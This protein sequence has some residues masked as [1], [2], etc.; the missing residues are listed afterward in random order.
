M[1]PIKTCV[2]G[3]GLAGLTFHVPFILALSDLFTLYAVL[4]RNPRSPGGKVKERFGVE[5]KIYN[6]I[7]EVVGDEEIEL[8]IVATPNDTHYALAKAALEAGKHGRNIS[9]S[10]LFP[11]K[12]KG[13][14]PI[15]IPEQAVGLGPHCPQK[16]LA[17]PPSSPQYLGN[18]LEFESHY[19]RYRP[20]IRASWKDGAGAVYDLGSHLLDQAL[21]LFDRPAKITAFIQNIRGV[22]KPEVD[23]IFTIYL[24]YN[25][26]SP[27]PNPFTVL[28]RSHILSAKASQL[29][30][31]VRGTEGVFTKYGLDTQEEQL[32]AMP[33]VRD[34]FAA[35]YGEEPQEI[36]GTVENIATD[37][38]TITK[39]IWLSDAPGQYVELFRNLAGAIRNNEELEVKWAETTQVIEM[40]EL[41]YKS[42]KEGLLAGLVHTRSPLTMS[43]PAV[44]IHVE[45]PAHSKSFDIRVPESATIL[46]VKQ[47][48][49][50]VCIG[51][52]RP[53][54]QRVIW[55]GRCL[56]DQEKIS[57]LWPCQDDQRIVHLSV[58]PSAWTSDPPSAV[59]T[60]LPSLHTTVDP[61]KKNPLA[62]SQQDSSSTR[63]TS[64]TNNSL[65]F[66]RFKHSQA[67]CWLS[68]SKLTAPSPLEDMDIKRSAAKL[69]LERLG[70]TWPDILDANCPLASP[71]SPDTIDYEIITIDGKAY[72]SLLT[73]RGTPSPLQIHA[74][75]VLTY[76]FSV[77][78]LPPSRPSPTPTFSVPN[79]SSVPPQVNDLLR[80]LGLPPL[81]AAPNANIDVTAQPDCR[82][83]TW[84]SRAC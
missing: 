45:L 9:I 41:A 74:L 17:L 59:S 54:G 50:S 36:Y 60:M 18:L 24:H 72:L 48:I 61:V 68:N 27:F 80:D 65:A 63:S 69:A 82:R 20:G 10:Y 19:D 29:R 62:G 79:T 7:D 15:W 83:S 55:R 67:L 56:D 13:T 4:E 34:I 37:H 38:V 66:I 32:K 33:T 42:S 21:K 22:T 43:V 84:H 77:L 78:A 12:I 52:P 76:T 5:T 64:D 49:S 6:T 1:A 73:P 81:R 57:V 51:H 31:T 16:L 40:I 47:A 8:V 75:N 30:Y 70:Y 23:D 58:R 39:S 46:D 25:I 35:G 44:V 11:N 26:G 28:L 53:D 2:L 14:C 71:T 3:V